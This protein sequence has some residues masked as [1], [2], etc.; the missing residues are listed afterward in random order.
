MI[1]TWKQ[2]LAGMDHSRGTSDKMR[3]ACMQA[4]IKALREALCRERRAL[5]EARALRDEWKTAA[6]RYQ[7][8][9]AG[10]RR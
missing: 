6:G 9:L 7:K 3:K 5:R 8:Q 10:E 2:R 4:E 1:A